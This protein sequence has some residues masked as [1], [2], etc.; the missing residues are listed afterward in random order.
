MDNVQCVGN[1]T[2]IADCTHNGWGVH[3]CGHYED[4]SVACLTSPLL[5]GMIT[6][7]ASVIIFQAV[8]KWRR[9]VINLGGPGPRPPL[10]LLQSSF[11]PF[12][13][14]D[15]PVSLGRAYS[16]AAKH[17]DA[18]YTANGPKKSTLMFNVLQKSACMQSSATVGRTDTMGYRPCIGAWH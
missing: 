6:L 3:N 14:M 16:A 10:S 9:S 13:L 7:T 1:E 18:I 12:P 15:S 11:L 17:F 4:V 8:R 2:S 5:N